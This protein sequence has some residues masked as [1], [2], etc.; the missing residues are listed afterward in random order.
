MIVAIMVAV[1]AAPAIAL[2]ADPTYSVQL[3]P[4]GD[5]GNPDYVLLIASM[6][7]PEDVPLPTTVRL[8]LPDG[9]TVGWAGE[10]MGSGPENDIAREATISV[11]AE[12]TSVV[13]TVSES[14]DVQYDA[15]WV[16][17]ASEPDGTYYAT[18]RWIQSEPA[19]LVAFSVRLP[20]LAG[21]VEFDPEAVGQ[22][23]V[24]EV[25]ESLHTLPSAPLAPGESHVINIRYVPGGA[26]AGDSSG[27]SRSQ[28]LMILAGA[29]ALLI[30]VAALL[31]RRETAY[32]YAAEDGP[33]E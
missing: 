18:L 1:V 10:V 11:S 30:V 9:A 13:F 2:A 5:P 14:R 19:E 4:E 20:P 29:A 28:L 27:L 7:I 6:Q 26:A 22:P 21:S 23:Q 17:L 3:W 12:G 16:P 8:P 33:V 15:V 31:I 32:V 24:N 25:G